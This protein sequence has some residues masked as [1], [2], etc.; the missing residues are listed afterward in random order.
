MASKIVGLAENFIWNNFK[1]Y[2]LSYQTCLLDLI[3]PIKNINAIKPVDRYEDL[4]NF[5]DSHIGLASY[6]NGQASQFSKIPYITVN[7]APIQTSRCS[8]TVV[9][10]F[11]VVYATD[12]P[13]ADDGQT[14]Y[15]GS[16]SES[17]SSFRAGI[18]ASLDELFFYAFGDPKL[19][20]DG[21]II[22][23]QHYYTQSFFDFLCGKEVSNPTDP[24]DKKKW[25]YNIVGEVDDEST[26]TEVSQL[27]REDRSSQLNVFHLV[28]KIDIN[29]LIGDGG[30]Y[31]C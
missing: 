3:C 9:I 21:V 17:V 26:I 5:V 24:N 14:K 19:D 16:S 29:K 20:E 18:A 15:I 4:L 6:V 23:E 27:K 8:V 12:A 30:E 31:G 10:G 13:P 7:I 2:L 22:P 1:F 28:Y 11:D 25:A